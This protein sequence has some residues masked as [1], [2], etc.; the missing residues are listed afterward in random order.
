MDHQ[1][2]DVEAAKRPAAQQVSGTQ[3]FTAINSPSASLFPAYAGATGQ[4]AAGWLQNTSFPAMPAEANAAAGTESQD[5]RRKHRSVASLVHMA[6]IRYQSVYKTCTLPCTSTCLPGLR[7]QQAA[8]QL[9]PSSSSDSEPEEASDQPFIK[10]AAPHGQAVQVADTDSNS[11]ESPH[12]K[13]KRRRE[14]SK[15]KK[16]RK[17]RCQTD[18]KMQTHLYM[19]MLHAAMC[20]CKQLALMHDCNAA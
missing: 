4:H 9:L 3:S 16:H 1:P 2:A 20:T 17:S 12:R 7:L 5:A 8:E 15:H 19:R 13:H 18:Q 6:C 11:E 10:V 14:H